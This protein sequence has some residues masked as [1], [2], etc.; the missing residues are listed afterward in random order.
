[1]KKFLA[2][3]LALM[4]VM[5][6]AVPSASADE[7]GWRGRGDWGERH[8]SHDCVGCALVGGIVLGGI[9]GSALAG[10]YTAPPPAYS[11]PPPACYTQPGYWTQVPGPGGY[12]N[13]WVPPQTVCQ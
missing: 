1:M 12:Q 11:P 7:H 5:A 6:V 10:G 9:L 8:E 3:L 2:P 4:L 13:A